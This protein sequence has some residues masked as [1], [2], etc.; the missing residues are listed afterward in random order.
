MTSCPLCNS[1]TTEETD[2]C[3]F[4]GATSRTRPRKLKEAALQKLLEEV[5]VGLKAK[6]KELDLKL[7]RSLHGKASQALEAGRTEEASKLLQG[8]RRA[9]DLAQRRS[10]LM[11][12]IT[13]AKRQVEKAMK[14]GLDVKTARE[15]IAGL[16]ER[17]RSGTLDGVASSL[18]EA[19]KGINISGRAKQVERGIAAARKRISY[20]RERGGNTAKAMEFLRNAEAGL[21]EGDLQKASDFVKKANRAADYARKNARA[22]QL[23]SGVERELK[24][25]AARGADVGEGEE[26]LLGAKKALKSGVYADV[27]RWTRAARDF[28]K[29]ARRE[30]VA[31]ETIQRVER[32]LEEEAK[33]GSDLSAA[34]PHLEQAWKSLKDGK[35]SDVN[36]QLQRA[37]RIAEE[38]ARLR[39]ARESLDL[40]KSDIREL[41]SM[42]ADAGKAEEAMGHAGEALDK[43]DWRKFK[44]YMHRA[45]RAAKRARKEREQELILTTVEKLVEKAG[46]GGVSALGARELLAEVE[47]ALGKGR[48]TDIDTLVEAKFEAEAT[49][50][51]NEVLRQIGQLRTVMAEFKIAGIEVSAALGLLDKAEEALRAK[52]TSQ[53]QD[54]LERAE[55]VSEG[56]KEALRGSAERAMKALEEELGKL[57][58][59]EVHVPQA[60]E[61]LERAGKAME[62][63]NPVSALDLSN[64]AM[65]AC[66]KARQEHFDQIASLELERMKS[67]SVREEARKKIEEAKE[68]CAVLERAGVDKGALEEASRRAE[69]AL[70]GEDT[71]EL[72]IRL[73]MLEELGQSLRASLRTQLDSWVENVERSAE[74][75]GEKAEAE[76]IQADVEKARK[77]LEEGSV[78]V[79][80]EVYLTLERKLTEARDRQTQEEMKEQVKSLKKLSSQFV[81]VK[82]ILDELR[83]AGIDVSESKG[84]L[85]EA[86]KALQGRDIR[87][88]EPLLTELEE[89]ATSVRGSLV[90]AARDLIASARLRLTKASKHWEKIHEAEEL[91]RNSEELFQQG[92]FDEAIEFAKLAERKSKARME[93]FIDEANMEVRQKI[94]SMED[95]LSRLKEVIKDLSRAN[96]SIE[97]AEE[98]LQNV[99]EALE[100][101]DF[102]TAEDLLATVEEMA[103]V[104]ASGLKVA[105]QDL[106]QKTGATVEKVREEG[107]SVPRGEQVYETA[108]EV[109]EKGRYVEALEYCKVIEDILEGARQRSA[110]EEVSVYLDAVRQDLEELESRGIRLSRTEGLLDEIREVASG[111]DLKRARVLAES[112]RDLLKELQSATV[113]EGIAEEAQEVGA[114]VEEIRE[115]FQQAQSVVEAGKLEELEELFARARI[116]L[117]EEGADGMRPMMQEVR[118]EIDVAEEIGADVGVAKDI[119][120]EAEASLD[121]EPEAALE[122]L[123][124]ARDVVK[125]AVE[126]SLDEAQPE[127][128]LEL[129]EEGLE[130]GKWTRYQFYVRNVGRVPARRVGIRLRGDVEV[131]GLEPLSKLSPGEERRIEV[132][133]RAK[134]E[135]EIPIDVEV[136]YRSY[137]DGQ[138]VFTT[139]RRRIVASPAGTYVVEDV[140][141]VHADGRLISHQSRKTMDNIDEDIFSGMLTVVQDFVKDS[142][143]QRTKVGLKRLE[144]GESKII[145]ERGSYVYL[146]SVL[147]GEEPK[148]LPLYMAEVINEIERRYGEKLEKWTGLLSELEGI[149]EIVAKLIFFTHD[150]VIRGPEGMETAIGS[151]MNLIKG[152]KTLGLDF[153]ESEKL[154]NTAEELVAEDPGQAWDF[155][156]DAV[157]KALVTQQELQGR[158][159][160]GLQTLE[161]D[162]EDLAHLG[163]TYEGGRSELDKARRAL[164]KGD[165]ERAAKTLAGLEDSVSALKEQVVSER[166]G[167]DLEGLSLTLTSLEREGA[168]AS[169]PRDLLE[170]AKEALGEGKLGEVTRCLENAD[171]ISRDLR[172]SFVL[173]RYE[174]ELKS[175]KSV[176]QEASAAGMLTE[177]AQG[178]IERAEEAAETSNLDDLE[179]LVMKAREATLSQIEGNL[180]GKEPKVLVKTPSAGLQSGIWNRYV[181][182]VINKGNWPAKSVELNIGGDVKVKG[183]TKIDKL[184]PDEAK[185]LELGLWPTEEG[186]SMLDMEVSY[187]R[188]LDDAPF[189]MRDVRDLNV[190]PKNTYLVEDGLLFLTNGELLVHESRK[191]REDL[192]EEAFS[193][194][195]TAV[196]DFIKDSFEGKVGIKRMD[197]GDSKIL[198]ERGERAYLVTVVVGREPEL[199]PLYTLQILKEAEDLYGEHL[200][201][202]QG[203]PDILER[204][205]RI[206][207][208]VLLVTD[209][210]GADL[211]PLTSSPITTKLLYGVP[212]KERAG[213]VR[214]LRHEIEE[215]MEEGGL[216]NGV[217]VLES[218]LGREVAERAPAGPVPPVERGGEGYSIEVD[219]ATLKEYIEIVKEIDK[220]VNKTRGKAGLEFH[221]PVPR[222]AVRARSPTVAAAANSFKAMIMSHANAKDLDILQEGEIWKGVDLKMQIHE[223]ALAKAYKVWAKKIELILKSQDPWKIKEGIDRGGYEMGIEGQVVRILPGMVSFQAIVPPHVVVQEFAGGMVFMDTQMTVETKA[224]GFANEIIRILLESRKEL[225]VEDSHPISLRIAAGEGLKELLAMQKLYIMEEANAKDLVFVGEVGDAGYVL[226]C[227]IRGEAFTLA[228]D[229]A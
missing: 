22:H 98:S 123:Q 87:K 209:S 159:E 82:R 167:K 18:R 128:V 90:T 49:K 2:A 172:K 160:A 1:S 14:A 33:Q 193:N 19:L 219:D 121:E 50:K 3:R 73:R 28:A 221:W 91:L 138:E 194:M 137:F 210:E 72:H 43:G 179:F 106:L 178:I 126:G 125:K 163:V 109:L 7:A 120:K 67:A 212:R 42:K 97:G 107:L 208:K 56:L 31:E 53:A 174:D 48:Y 199:L 116:S 60:E 13:Q 184:A 166:I 46:K 58:D 229:T 74:D 223:E 83:K 177:E 154:L 100:E 215:A 186:E 211:G 195:L 180:E 164:T 132:G 10:S 76:T 155:I 144:F 192:D 185:M 15:E 224:Q 130:K 202:W 21:T 70:K 189:V 81:R 35:F 226:D 79:A 32:V 133:V 217:K 207:R 80:L 157:E 198:M 37:R 30:K 66:R 61:F 136:A 59:L 129:P 113:E 8:L 110:L 206:V 105:A 11:E 150:D 104:L 149:D 200:Q 187:K 65:E 220:A 168:D 205:R 227:E 222:I 25:A 94:A 183:K 131:K 102:E 135:G 95:R 228:V 147:M 142:F 153:S 38:A 213:W 173:K 89:M 117:G 108:R 190:A 34:G 39:K 175:L 96:I 204:L 101:A 71:E 92:R 20:A 36:K 85:Q 69:E 63:G 45:T 146:A 40:L 114:R 214:G 119:L 84:R 201:D 86:E 176:Y 188:F 124:R 6:P 170:K 112:V 99:E 93:R 54:L 197:F 161:G 4:C 111:G 148:L 77:A 216:E 141:L 143:R 145:I 140:F 52:K 156:Q 218:A 23:I 191:F 171:T 196:Q 55:E 5:S 162:M 47:K 182:E 158:L 26:L 44:Q 127:I 88:A 118:E 68:F 134:A 139:E 12:K 165:Y 169:K 151:A 57:T 41:H 203:D 64:L 122:S 115:I 9:I 103:E 152:G 17:V 16:E 51:E 181:V 75:I 24:K 62:D 78:E 29:R 27:Q 225:A